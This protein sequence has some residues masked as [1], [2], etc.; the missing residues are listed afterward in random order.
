[1]TD[2]VSHNLDRNEYCR[3]IGAYRIIVDD[4]GNWWVHAHGHSPPVM[5]GWEKDGERARLAAEGYLHGKWR[6]M[7]VDGGWS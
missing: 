1:M 6:K 5:R 3:D 7:G 4:Q 2:Y